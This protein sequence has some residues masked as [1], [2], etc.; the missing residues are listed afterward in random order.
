MKII[1]TAHRQLIDCLISYGV[2]KPE[3]FRLKAD[4][5]RSEF[6]I[7]HR[8]PNTPEGT[9]DLIEHVIKWENG[10]QY[11]SLQKEL[12]DKFNVSLK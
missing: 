2:D 1:D 10:K 8:K 6:D 3:E 9:K 12:D 11:D 4:L 7:T 5:L